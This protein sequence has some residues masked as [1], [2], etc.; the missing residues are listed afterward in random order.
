MANQFGFLIIDKPKGVTSHDCVQKVRRIFSIKKVGH[1]GTLD[2]AVTGV[3]PIAIGNATRL[4]PYL[5]GEKTY[6]GVIQLG[7]RTT[8][9]D[10]QGEV[11]N[12]NTWPIISHESID[13]YLENF[14]GNIKQIPPNVSSVHI[15]GERAYKKVRRGETFTLQEKEVKIYK[16]DLQNWNQTKGQITIKVNCSAG[17]Y[18][19]SIARDIGNEIGCGGCLKELRR[20]KALGFDERQAIILPEKA[21]LNT[22]KDSNIINPIQGLKHLEKIQLITPEDENKWKTGQIIDCS[23]ENILISKSYNDI[24]PEK[25]F[26]NSKFVV[27]LGCDGDIEGIGESIEKLLLKPKVVFNAYG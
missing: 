12:K 21:Q 14:R 4:L 10:L 19:R 1:G 22:I 16:L 15:E 9:D 7:C 18:I 3:L 2:P 6:K 27:V 23:N 13:N 5:P 17:T 20:V 24:S 8:T 25:F 11:I 26:F